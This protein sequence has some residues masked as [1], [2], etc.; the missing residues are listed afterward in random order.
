MSHTSSECLSACIV[1]VFGSFDL[2][3]PVSTKRLYGCRS[4]ISYL[5]HTGFEVRVSARLEAFVSPLWWFWLAK[6]GLSRA[7]FNACENSRNQRAVLYLTSALELYGI[8]ETWMHFVC[9]CWDGNHRRFHDNYRS[10]LAEDYPSV[11]PSPIISHKRLSTN[12]AV[13]I[14]CWKA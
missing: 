14:L 12:S 9:E 13:R 5:F 4:A 2:L 7:K 10:R 11:V 8:D 3:P 1:E 6:C